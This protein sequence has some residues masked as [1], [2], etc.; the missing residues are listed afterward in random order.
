MKNHSLKLKLTPWA[1]LKKKLPRLSE[2]CLTWAKIILLELKFGR[3]DWVTILFLLY[4]K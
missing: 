4:Q 3:E 2:N 1:L